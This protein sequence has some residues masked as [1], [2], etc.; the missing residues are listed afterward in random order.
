MTERQETGIHPRRSHHTVVGAGGA[1]MQAVAAAPG[2]VSEV[3]MSQP[4]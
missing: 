3:A 2:I 1:T 4:L